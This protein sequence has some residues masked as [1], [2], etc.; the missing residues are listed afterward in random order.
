VHGA[1]SRELADTGTFLADPL[2]Q[3]CGE[4]AG[5]F[6]RKWGR[7]PSNTTAHWA[8]ANVLV[9][10][11]HDGLTD[12]EK[13]IRAAGHTRLLL[14]GRQL[15][16]QI[17]EDELKA[18]VE[19]ATQREVLTMLS[20]TRL[21]PDLSAEVFLLGQPRPPY[22]PST[23]SNGDQR[24]SKACDVVAEAHALLGEA[25]Q[26]RANHDTLRNHTA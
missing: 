9:V 2:A 15:L 17:L 16:Q 4:V 12:H 20:A 10:L 7:G 24:R 3:I 11:L 25:R 22:R 8:G 5:A 26:A 18:I 14:D 6:R 21:D 23:T 13:T 19:S 1:R